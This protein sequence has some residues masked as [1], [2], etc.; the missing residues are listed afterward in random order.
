MIDNSKLAYGA[1]AYLTATTPKG[2]VSCTFLMSK[3]KVAPI[4]TMS[5]P[6]LKLLAATLGAELCQYLTRAVLATS[7]QLTTTE[8]ML[9]CGS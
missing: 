8:V 2:E 7:S 9:W 5:V 1:V 3:S 4:Q 6:R